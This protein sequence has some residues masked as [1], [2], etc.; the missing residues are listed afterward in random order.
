MQGIYD[1]IF[2]IEAIVA[3]S[4]AATLIDSIANRMSTISDAVKV[5][6]PPTVVA[7]EWT[8]P[9]FAMGNWG[10]ELVEAANGRLC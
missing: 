3:S 8:D 6:H 4:E 1:G 9:T 5:R 7:L 10:P 2:A